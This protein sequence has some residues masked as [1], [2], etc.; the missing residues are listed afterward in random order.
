[1]RSCTIRTI[2]PDTGMDFPAVVLVCLGVIHSV[3]AHGI[4]PTCGAPDL[5]KD[6]GIQGGTQAPYSIGSVLYYSC[7][8]GFQLQ[9]AWTA[10]RLSYTG[11]YW[12]NGPPT[13]VRKQ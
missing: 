5:P 2:R 3:A 13:C 6:G 10:C 8:N 4:M 12:Q 9:A 1:M 11:T 7:N